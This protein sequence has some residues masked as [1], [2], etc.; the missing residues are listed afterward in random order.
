MNIKKSCFIPVCA[1]VIYENGAKVKTS[2]RTNLDPML[3]RTA[4]ELHVLLK[5]TCS[6]LKKARNLPKYS[7]PQ[8]VFTAS[9]GA[10]LSNCGVDY[11]IKR[12]DAVFIRRLD[13]QIESG[14]TLF[15]GG[16]LLSKKAA[17]EKAAAEKKIP[18]DTIA[19]ELSDRE[20]DLVN[21]LK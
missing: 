15:G 13:S 11:R 17:A 1:D 10:K 6:K 2:F 14:K 18:D 4:P 8:E 9:I 7:Y 5:E 12:D 20:R 21:S 3:V 19:W 16:L